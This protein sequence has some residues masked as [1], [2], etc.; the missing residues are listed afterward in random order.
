MHSNYSTD[1]SIELTIDNIDTSYNY[2]NVY[3]S[4]YSSDKF[5]L[6]NTSIYKILDKYPILSSNSVKIRITGDENVE[7]IT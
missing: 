6:T 5:S 7:E 1:K 2:I 4:K 3:Y